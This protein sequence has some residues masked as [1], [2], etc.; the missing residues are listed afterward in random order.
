MENERRQ[1]DD[2][3]NRLDFRFARVRFR[4]RVRALP[5]ASVVHHFCFHVS[6]WGWCGS[7]GGVAP[8]RNECFPWRGGVYVMGRVL[9]CERT[10]GTSG[11][12][13]FACGLKLPS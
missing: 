3:A 13:A 10:A 5:S 2:R 11:R 4:V 9:C 12:R 7:L 6:D 1:D 8:R